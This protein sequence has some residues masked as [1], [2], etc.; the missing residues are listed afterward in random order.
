MASPPLTFGQ[1]FLVLLNRCF[2]NGHLPPDARPPPKSAGGKLQKNK[3]KRSH[4]G[5]PTTTI[6]TPTKYQTGEQRLVLRFPGQQPSAPLP[7]D[8]EQVAVAAL[9][10]DASDQ[11]NRIPKDI[12]SLG[13]FVTENG[14]YRELVNI[15]DKNVKEHPY[16]YVISLL[17]RLL[18]EDNKLPF[19]YQEQGSLLQLIVEFASMLK[20]CKEPTSSGGGGRYKTKKVGG[21]DYLWASSKIVLFLRDCTRS[22]GPLR[23]AESHGFWRPTEEPKKSTLGKFLQT[24]YADIFNIPLSE[25]ALNFCDVISICKDIERSTD[26]L[27]DYINANCEGNDCSK[28]EN[29]KE[30]YQYNNVMLC[31]VFRV[32]AAADKSLVDTFKEYPDA[33]QSPYNYDSN[34]SL[35]DYL[36]IKFQDGS[37]RVAGM[38][39]GFEILKIKGIIKYIS[40]RVWE[41]E[42]LSTINTLNEFA[43]NDK[44]SND[45]NKNEMSLRYEGTLDKTCHTI[46]ASYD[47]QVEPTVDE[48]SKLNKELKEKSLSFMEYYEKRIK[49]LKTKKIGHINLEILDEHCKF[50]YVM[51]YM[52]K[53]YLHEILRILRKREQKREQI[54]NRFRSAAATAAAAAVPSIATVAVAAAAAKKAAPQNNKPLGELETRIADIE[55]RLRGIEGT[56][57]S[58]RPKLTAPTSSDKDGLVWRDNGTF[59]QPQQEH[60]LTGGGSVKFKKTS[61]K[62]TVHVK[63]K[64]YKRV[65]YTN[66]RGTKYIMFQGDYK[67]LSYFKVG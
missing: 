36:S 23:K 18:S 45:G 59:V 26:E 2:P 41:G 13:N 43:L 21:I 16:S 24:V 52:Y 64:A 8:K 47:K 7:I 14:S 56:L 48:A 5:T 22:Y 60:P 51:E 12:Y 33:S 17:D 11:Y 61:A 46:M 39:F 27:Q 25:R 15:E 40:S 65:V 53:E 49:T 57:A 20:S 3:A 32:A 10:R 29:F 1:G 9:L 28:I 44:A 58:F 34:I 62:I 42:L 6:T 38:N 63:S 19:S 30:K 54:R 55:R 50:V 37:S 35:F 4:G 66:N 67:R 31:I